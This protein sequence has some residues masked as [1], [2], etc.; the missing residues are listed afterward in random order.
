MWPRPRRR[1]IDSARRAS[2]SS[3]TR[4]NVATAARPWNLYCCL[5][6]DPSRASFHVATAAR[7]WNRVLFRSHHS[8]GRASRGHG[9][10]AVESTSIGSLVTPYNVLQCGHGRAAVES[11]PDGSSP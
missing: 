4:F 6:N 7:P 5:R 1:G 3:S 2:D 9:R 10:A 8:H 11:G